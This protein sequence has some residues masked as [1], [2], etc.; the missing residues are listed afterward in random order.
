MVSVQIFGVKNSQATR[1]AERF[2][3]ERRAE[4]HM[5]D[6]KQKPIAPGEIKRFVDRFGLA[7]ILD[8]EGKSY[9]DAGL[10]YIK[11]SDAGML[12]RMEQEP[13]LMRLP[14][15]RSGKLLSVGQDEETWKAMMARPAR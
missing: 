7:G 13:K 9:I 1:A 10:K 6:L 3:K 8:T 12:Q 15:I 14:L 5:V 4:I 11:H 2:F